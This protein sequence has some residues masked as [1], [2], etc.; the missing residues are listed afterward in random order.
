MPRCFGCGKDTPPYELEEINND[1]LFCRE[2]RELR[3]V[4]GS[5][6]KEVTRMTKDNGE[7][8]TQQP[9]AALEVYQ[10]GPDNYR[11]S[12]YVRTGGIKL[13][14]NKTVEEIRDFFTRRRTKRLERAASKADRRLQSVPQ[15][16]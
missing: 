6:Q 15:E 13:E 1:E 7:P 9:V 14:I 16:E 3:P 2:C 11:I 8:K 10:D 4:A 12:A 5:H